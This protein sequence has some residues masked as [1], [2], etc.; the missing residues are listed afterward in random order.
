ML[1]SNMSRYNDGF[2]KV[3]DEID[4]AD[5]LLIIWEYRKVIITSFFLAIMIA[6]ISCISKPRKYIAKTTIINMLDNKILRNAR[7]FD[8]NTIVQSP[9]NNILLAILNSASLREQV[10]KNSNLLPLL[11]PGS[12]DEKNKKW[13]KIPE[14]KIPVASKGAKRLKSFVT[15]SSGNTKPTISIAVISHS[16]DLSVV[17]ANAYTRELEIFLK[18]NT[19]SSVKKSRLFLEK[20]LNESKKK[21]DEF[22]NK[23][24]SF[25]TDNGVF[26]LKLQIEASIKA[27]NTNALMLNSIETEREII[28]A[29]SSSKNP[30]VINLT[31]RINTIQ[32]KMDYLKRGA[33]LATSNA[34]EI[35][36]TIL[37]DSN[38]KL[39]FIPLNR[40]PYLKMQMN[41]LHHDIK[42]Q[43]KVY[44]LIVE[45]YEKITIQEAQDK[46]FIKV[47]D[48]AEVPTRSMGRNTKVTL[49]LGGFLG[50]CLGVF[51]AFAL[52]FYSY[53]KAHLIK[54]SKTQKLSHTVS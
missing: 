10:V 16:P 11:F 50:I 25:Q 28:E 51:I 21:L 18:N 19:F 52:H 20:Q 2:K 36:T 35:K 34:G 40:I 47:L 12:W 23:M 1:D 6:G 3:E 49:L 5:L 42:L 4:L 9:R 39:N 45:S 14:K 54:R 8:F 31:K 46:I 15:I 41:K 17:I 30:K 32:K 22:K 26:D 38:D 13:K 37:N 44:D 29:I 43:Q 27:Y 7:G 33:G 48:R 24:E 53:F